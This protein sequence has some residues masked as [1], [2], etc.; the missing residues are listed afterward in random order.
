MEGRFLLLGSDVTY[1]VTAMHNVG[2]ISRERGYFGGDCSTLQLVQN[3]T[4]LL[5]STIIS[6]VNRAT[7]ARLWSQPASKAF[8]S[9]WCRARQIVS[10]CGASN[11][12]SFIILGC[13]YDGGVALP[14]HCSFYTSVYLNQSSLIF[15]AFI[16]PF[17]WYLYTLVQHIYLPLGRL[18][19]M[20][21]VEW[22][23]CRISFHRPVSRH[24][25]HRHVQCGNVWTC[26]GYLQKLRATCCRQY[27]RQS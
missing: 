15:V 20:V 6:E 9:L 11:R 5:T 26:C 19:H 12:Q 21:N 3:T 7:I 23:P 17:N 22:P 27:T 10:G 24:W 13:L 2:N 25:L 18:C 8:L 16:K 14:L 1:S 4:S